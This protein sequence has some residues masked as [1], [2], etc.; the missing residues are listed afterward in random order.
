MNIKFTVVYLIEDGSIHQIESGK[1]MFSGMNPVYNYFWTSDTLG[2]VGEDEYEN[3][4]ISGVTVANI[5][6]I[7]DKQY[8]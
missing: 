1:N 8:P 5:S 6:E 3:M 2:S 7:T 4:L